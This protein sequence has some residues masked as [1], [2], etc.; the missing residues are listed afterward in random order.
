MTKKR[1][2]FGDTQKPP[3]EPSE[4]ER[5]VAYYRAA[6]AKT[7]EA[8]R[9]A[10]YS[11]SVVRYKAASIC[12]RESV[13]QA[14]LEIEAAIKPN[15]LTRMSKSLIQHKL[16]TA[17]KLDKET[18]GYLRTGCE[19]EGSLGNSTELGLHLHEHHQAISPEVA[20]MVAQ[21]VKRAFSS[22]QESK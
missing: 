13:K 4:R 5:A 19:L 17:K 14:L 3:R 8:V 18:L 7:T 20:E 10:G 11:P 15:D 6:G 1:Y 9:L 12:K 21:A 22:E 2:T 16:T